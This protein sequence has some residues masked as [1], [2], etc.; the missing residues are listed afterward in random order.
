MKEERLIKYGDI[1]LFLPVNQIVLF[2]RQSKTE[3]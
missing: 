3:I 2:F 1:K